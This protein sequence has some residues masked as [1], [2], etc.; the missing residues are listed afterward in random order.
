MPMQIKVL[1]IF[2][3]VG[4][5]GVEDVTNESFFP[6]RILKKT[7]PKLCICKKRDLQVLFCKV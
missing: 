7:M 1:S 5:D 2:A 4:T 3:V 6:F